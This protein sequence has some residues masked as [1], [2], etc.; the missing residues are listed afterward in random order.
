VCG[1]ISLFEDFLLGC[2]GCV[3]PKVSERDEEIALS[4]IP[5]GVGQLPTVLGKLVILNW[6]SHGW[7]LP[8]EARADLFNI[9][10]VGD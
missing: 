9:A 7:M 2:D 3:F 8:H 6:R 10:Q 5:R 4:C 1:R